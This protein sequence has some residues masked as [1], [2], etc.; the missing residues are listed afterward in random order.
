M[1]RIL[2]HLPSGSLALA[3]MTLASYVFGLLRDRTLAQT[4]G[5]SS[6]LDAYNAAFLLPDFLLNFLVAGGIAAAV[7][8]IFIDLAKRNKKESEEYIDTV[9][10]SSMITMAIVAIVLFIFAEPATIL[11]APGFSMAQRHEVASLLRI[12]TLSPIIFAASNTLGALL[13]ASKRF[14]FYGLSPLLYNVGII[15]GALFLTPYFGIEGIAIGTV[16]GA[17]L[18]L[19]ARLYDIRSL[20]ISLKPLLHIKTPA[21]KKS[22]LL[23]LPK[24]VG[25]PVELAT[26]WGFTILASSLAPGSIVIMNFARNFQSVPVSLIGLVLATTTFPH[27]AHAFVDKS[28]KEFS[29]ILKK[30]SLQILAGSILAAIFLYLIRGPLIAHLIGGKAFTPED[31]SRT[32]AFLGVFTLSIPTEALNQLIARAFYATKN[33]LLPTISSVVALIVSVSGAW[34]MLPSMQILALPLAFFLGSLSKIVILLVLL[35]SRI[36]SIN[37]L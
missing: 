34:L 19:L 7:V 16:I 6:A 37:Q 20:G 24:M 22:I 3:T 4:F 9:L 14:M 18:H 12:L 11:V 21:F 2:K 17:L 33:T 15:G 35:P 10:T 28:A 36:R 8:P 32:A 25:H 30:S 23:T 13:V 27:L 29:A 1:K 26:Y 5:A 31:V